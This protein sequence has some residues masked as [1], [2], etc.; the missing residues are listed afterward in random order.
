MGAG[1]KVFTYDV[2]TRNETN[3][4]FEQQQKN[5]GSQVSVHG[6]T[7]MCV[8]AAASHSVGQAIQ[9]RQSSSWTRT[10]RPAQVASSPYPTPPLCTPA[11]GR[12]DLQ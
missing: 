1:R 4:R 10:W 11:A 6:S 9:A 2:D 8:W 5:L 3:Y 12:S 7:E